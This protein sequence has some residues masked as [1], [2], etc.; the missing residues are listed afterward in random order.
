MSNAADNMET[1]EASVVW[2]QLSQRIDALVAAWEGA[3]E[4]PVLAEFVPAE[5]ASLR[6]LTLVEAVK[7]DLEYRWKDRRFPKLVE[8]YVEEFPELAAD[9]GV[10]CDLIYEEYHVR[11][12]RG[13][14]VTV[15]EYCQRFPARTDELRRLFD[16]ECPE[17]TSSLVP[18]ERAPVFE[19]GQQIDDFD[20]LGS[21]GK[22][23]FA[24]VF[25]A[26][27]RSMQRL[28]ALKISRDKGFEPQTL[29]QLDHA[30][31]V[32]VFD[33]RQLAAQKLRLLYMQYV[34]GGTLKE[35]IEHIR[36][37]PPPSATARRC[38][39]PSTSP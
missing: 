19:V 34:P 22:G 31:I 16:L 1:T 25:L 39:R 12:Q 20:L 33:Q 36:Q 15:V 24:S 27:Q 29:A 8:A 10:P 28:V 26:R 7:V 23:A 37:L 30:H 14:A 11:K 9:G 18:A 5:P 4:P 21:L 2:R 38:W 17:Q 32:R 35:V 6:R 3:S 13:D